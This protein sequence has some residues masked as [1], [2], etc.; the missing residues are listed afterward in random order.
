MREK[1]EELV[2]QALAD[3]QAA[4]E[5]PEFQIDDVGLER[6]Q[7]SSNGDWSSTV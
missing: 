1:I 6:P 7:D 5:L 2:R 3:A 4:G